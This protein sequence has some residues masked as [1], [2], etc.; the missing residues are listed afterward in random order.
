MCIRDS[1]HDMEGYNGRL[2][3]I[4]A[5]ILQT[6]LRF[7]SEWNTE[8]RK[9]ASAYQK[10][11]AE[12]SDQLILPHEPSWANSANHLYVIR[13]E[14]R[15]QL[16]TYLSKFSIG[17]AIHY[18][19]PLH[20]QKA[21]GRLGYK[22]GDFPVSERAA[23]QVLS[24]PMYPQIKADQQREVADRIISFVSERADNALSLHVP[25]PAC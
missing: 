21:Y 20:L 15:D 1:Y 8:R 4:Q 17:T 3:A 5:G 9:R 19:V 18:P 14:L 13:S 6:K 23:R 24:L 7:L 16:R 12:T 11:L 2:D 25:A 10:L 22:E